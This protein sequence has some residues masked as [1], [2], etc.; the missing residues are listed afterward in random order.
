MSKLKKAD[1]Y[2]I[3]ILLLL[4]TGIVL[5]TVDRINSGSNTVSVSTGS[6][7]KE[8]IY[9]DYNGKKVGIVTC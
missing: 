2:I 4:I 6:P 8:V 5:F 9:T 1:F 7:E 3:V